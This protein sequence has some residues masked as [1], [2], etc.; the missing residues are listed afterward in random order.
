MEALSSA[1]IPVYAER[2]A[3]GGWVLT[4]GY[5]TN[6]TGMKEEEMTSLLLAHSSSLLSDL[7]LGQVLDGALQ[8]LVA[9]LPSTLS[10]TARTVRERI[11]VDGAGWHQTE[12]PL[13]ALPVVQ[14][15]VWQQKKL[16]LRYE[17]EEEAV[18]RI[19]APLGLVAKSSIW[20]LVAEVEGT[21]RTYRVSRIAEVRMLDETFQRPTPFD[22]ALYWEE[23]T[24]QFKATLPR[25][26]ARIRLEQH[27]LTRAA[28][29]RY[30]RILESGKVENGW[31]ELDVEFH[32]LHSAT[33]I[34]LSYGA[35]V[36]VL[37]P[38]ELSEQIRKVAREIVDRYQD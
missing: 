37:T 1:G 11:H 4:E 28:Q 22:L 31:I 8:K 9:A 26:P 17:R 36:E 16:A 38:T 23:S 12:Q 7:G 30:M 24:K 20:Y 27:L 2:G 29:Q 18:E 35:S 14:E 10:D 33:E 5:R 25:Y 15:A 13:P 34:L 6:L 3:H 19:V 32:T 21:L